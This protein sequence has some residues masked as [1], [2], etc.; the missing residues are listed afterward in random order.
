MTV[1]IPTILGAIQRPAVPVYQLSLDLTSIEEAIELAKLGVAAGVQVIEAGTI[2]LL[3]EGARLTLPRLRRE[4]PQHPIVADI[5][6]TDG[7]AF[8]MALV[9]ELGASKATVMAAASDATIKFSVREAANH[10]GCEV[11]VD[12]MGFGGPHGLDVQGQIDAAKRARD[13]GAHYV[14]LHLGYD[15]RS[16]NR[17]MVEDNVLLRWAEAVAGEG[18]DIPIQV[19]GGLTL[20]QASELPQF[21]ISDIVISMNLGSRPV[22]DMAYDKITGFTVDLNDPD[23]RERVSDQLR[24]FMDV[25]TGKRA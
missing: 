20:A 15:E 11:M 12:T 2:L 9:F 3:S 19:V 13:L 14:V 7:A 25:T 23:D 1:P 5:K 10:P 4:F 8:E 18:L 6:C 24:Q 17:R 21:G 22:G 16:E